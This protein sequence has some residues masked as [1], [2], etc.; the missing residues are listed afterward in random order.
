MVLRR[1]HFLCWMSLRTCSA[2]RICQAALSPTL[3][4]RR[5][6]SIPVIAITG[7]FIGMVMAVETYTRNFKATLGQENRLGTVINLSVVKQIGPVVS[8][9]GNAPVSGR[10][11]TRVG[12]RPRRDW[13]R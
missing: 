10:A 1:P 2:G 6:A 9:R 8:G 3:R 11:L 4:N 13:A 7:C 12:Q 5:A